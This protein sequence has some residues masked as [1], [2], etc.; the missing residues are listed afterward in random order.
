ME[1]PGDLWVDYC[2][3]PAHSC[4]SSKEMNGELYFFPHE[5]GPGYWLLQTLPP[6]KAAQ[7]INTRE[8]H[9]SH[10]SA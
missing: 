9:P 6:F 3:S 5:D 8:I 4:Y 1:G 2:R 7:H 10:K